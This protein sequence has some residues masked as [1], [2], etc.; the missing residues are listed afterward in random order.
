MTEVIASHPGGWVERNGSSVTGTA[1]SSSKCSTPKAWLFL[2]GHYRTFDYTRLSMA[3]AMAMATDDCYFVVAAVWPTIGSSPNDHGVVHDMLPPNST[4]RSSGVGVPKAGVVSS[5]HLIRAARDFGGRMAFVILSRDF[6]KMSMIKKGHLRSGFSTVLPWHACYELA[7]YAATTHNFAIDPLSTVVRTRP[8]FRF[9][10]SW[11][12]DALRRVFEKGA[13]RQQPEIL[14][15]GSSR[16]SPL[17]SE[18]VMAISLY[19]TP[20][21]HH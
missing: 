5:D 14:L 17:A 2:F 18:D 10:Y 6:S 3:T 12:Q 20:V 9:T 7:R 8:D 19:F 21:P 15:T 13:R 1:G 16:R 11:D 4:Q